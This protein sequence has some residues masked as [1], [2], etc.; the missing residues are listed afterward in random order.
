MIA[1][2][3]KLPD[4]IEASKTWSVCDRR[5]FQSWLTE[6]RGVE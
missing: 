5:I 4:I 1:A 6:K 2:S 3:G